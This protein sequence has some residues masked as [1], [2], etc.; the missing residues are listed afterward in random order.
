MTPLELKMQFLT[1]FK[2]NTAQTPIRFFGSS[3]LALYHFRLR[4]TSGPEGCFYGGMP[5]IPPET[6]GDDK[7]YR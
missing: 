7:I 5:R 4:R 3:Q 1:A 2:Q 6:G